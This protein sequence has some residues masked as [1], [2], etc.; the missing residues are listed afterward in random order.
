[1]QCTLCNEYIDEVE[2]E[3]DDVVQIEEEYW[4]GEC[5]AEYFDESEELVQAV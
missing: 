4:H 1:M 2:L 3:F 5:Y